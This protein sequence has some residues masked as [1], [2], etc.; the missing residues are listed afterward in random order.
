[1]C[2][3]HSSTHPATLMARSGALQEVNLVYRLNAEEISGRSWLQLSACLDCVW[4]QI[5][6]Q[7]L[8]LGFFSA[9]IHKF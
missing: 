2:R 6:S 1:M 8:G 4:L 9:C 5:K 3:T 7:Q